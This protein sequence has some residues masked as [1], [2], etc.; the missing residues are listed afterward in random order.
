MAKRVACL[1]LMVV[2]FA[3]AGWTASA[4]TMSEVIAALPR[5]LSDPMLL[6][7]HWSQIRTKLGLETVTSD[8]PLDARM[9]LARRSTEELAVA[10]AYGRAHLGTHAE[11]WGWDLSDLDWEAQ[12]ISAEL[13]PIYVLR[14]RDG[15]DFSRISAHLADRGFIQTESYGALAFTHDL[16]LSQ[17]WLH[18]TELSILNMAYVEESRLMILSSSPAAV[19]LCLAAQSGEAASLDQ[20]AFET[21]AVEHLGAVDSAILLRGLSECLRFSPGPIVDLVDSLPTSEKLADVKL[22]LEQRELLAPYRAFGIGY[23]DVRGNRVGTIVFEYDTPDMA[24]TDMPARLLLAEEGMSAQFD[25]PIREACFTVQTC[26]VRD[27]AIVMSV[28]P[29]ENRPIRLFRMVFYRDAIF[30]GCS[31]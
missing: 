18:T 3:L 10:S 23:E 19:D 20:D 31:M 7:T 5:D 24:S 14:L 22:A 8:S 27:S 26:E 13:P 29:A 16:D 2:P 28:A 17:E 15:F 12:L 1:L 9:E 4:I 25:A 30:A 11:L 21:A 6:F